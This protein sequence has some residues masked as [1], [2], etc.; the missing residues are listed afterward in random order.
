[1]EEF[2]KS[3][4]EQTLSVI[5]TVILVLGLIGT[6]VSFFSLCVLWDYSGMDG[7]NWAGIPTAINILIASLLGWS[8]LN[9]MV[10]I[11]MNIR[12]LRKLKASDKVEVKQDDDWRKEFA[13][14]I[15]LEQKDKARELLYRRILT[16]DLFKR[17]LGNKS[18]ANNNILMKDLNDYFIIY[19]RAI[20]EE[21]FNVESQNNIYNAF[22]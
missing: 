20:G 15:T 13:V 22:K 6:A 9:V 7:I 18:Q 2:E 4:A 17:V 19:L 5:A 3:S 12:T 8:L 1:M 16:S 11:S 14:L 21:S 10:E